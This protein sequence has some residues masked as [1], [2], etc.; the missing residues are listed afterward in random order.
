MAADLFDKIVAPPGRP[1]HVAR[2]TG[3]DEVTVSDAGTV[4][5]L[6]EEAAAE[7]M[8]PA[9]E[10]VEWRRKGHRTRVVEEHPW[11]VEGVVV[12]QLTD[13]QFKFRVKAALSASS[14]TTLFGLKHL[15]YNGD[16][17][18]AGV[19]CRVDTVVKMDQ[20]RER[21]RGVLQ[22]E[23]DIEWDP[24]TPPPADFVG[25][26][27]PVVRWVV[28][29]IDALGNEDIKYDINGKV[30][31]GA[32]V[33]V[34]NSG[35]EALNAVADRLVAAMSTDRSPS[36]PVVTGGAVKGGAL[37]MSPAAVKKRLARKARSGEPVPPKGVVEP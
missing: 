21:A 3:E 9:D 37:S 8:P 27:K 31:D 2:A 15:Q 26:R 17:R 11:L 32:T 12:S 14:G 25:V 7:M 22:G 29:W 1:A 24:S 6:I 4:A 33:V 13:A 19:S 28:E 23:T 36:P 30:R 20:L 16:W 18:V 35:A 5:A 10:V 34:N